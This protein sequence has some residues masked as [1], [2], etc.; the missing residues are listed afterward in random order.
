MRPIKFRAWHI[1][2]KI[3]FDVDEL[4]V[5]AHASGMTADGYRIGGFFHANLGDSVTV[6]L[7]QFT[8]L[9]DKNGKEIWEGDVV[10]VN[11]Q[12]QYSDSLRIK[13]NGLVV[14]SEHAASFLIQFNPHNSVSKFN[15]IARP[16]KEKPVDYIKSW[17]RIDRGIFEVLGNIYEN[18]ELLGSSAAGTPNL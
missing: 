6:N 15:D 16:K 9:H 14:W 4:T 18:P 2:R 12:F 8:G 10:H 3:M 13:E 7:M 17:L 5:S 1:G 11:G